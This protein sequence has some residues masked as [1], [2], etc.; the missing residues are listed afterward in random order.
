VD[1]MAG[2]IEIQPNDPGP[3]TLARVV[4]PEHES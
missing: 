3:G 1:L 2:T 4:L